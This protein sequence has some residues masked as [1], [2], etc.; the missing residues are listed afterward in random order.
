MMDYEL[1]SQTRS[2]HTGFTLIELLVV[3]AIIAILA[4]VLFPVFAQAREKARQSQ[5]VSNLRQVSAAFQMYLQDY[6]ETFPPAYYFGQPNQTQP[7]NYGQYFWTWLT[8]PYTKSFPVYYCPSEPPS[9]HRHLEDPFFGYVFG[10]FPAWGYN[11]VY[12]SPG[13]D[14][15]YPEI[16]PFHPIPLA[17]V[18]SSSGTLLLVESV[19]LE[20]P[21]GYDAKGLG[22]FRVLPPS[23]WQGEPPLSSLS[24][25]HCW[26]RHSHQF[27]NS[28]F[29]DGHVKPLT[30]DHL[31][32]Q[33]LWEAER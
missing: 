20:A 17:R 6:D 22:Y 25:G 9:R 16:D 8:R 26:R 28:A 13:R 10:R 27:A 31:R 33:A 24:Y 23:Y 4:A 32:Q 7:N 15:Y 19:Y 30:L 21:R 14:P 12:L 11:T 2:K 5:C 3:I 18:T 29:V 1:V